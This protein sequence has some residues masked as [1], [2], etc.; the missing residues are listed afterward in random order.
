MTNPVKLVGVQYLRAIAALMVV[1][2]H[3]FSTAARYGGPETNTHWLAYGVD[4]F[5]VISGCIMWITT[6][7]RTIGA[8]EFYSK[9]I[10]RIVPLYW[11][12][13][14]A[15]AVAVF[16]VPSAFNTARFDL[17]HT[18]ASLLFIPSIHPS[19]GAFEPLL[20]Q[21]WTLN[22]EMFF[23]LLF[24]AALLISGLKRRL[25]VAAVVLA[26]FS[27]AGVFVDERT[28]LGFYTR[29]YLLEFG[30]GMLLGA[31]ILNGHRL[32]FGWAWVI[33]GFALL[34]ALNNSGLPFLVRASVPAI[35][36]VGGILSWEDRIGY[37]P[38]PKVMGDASYSIYLSNPLVIGVLTVISR[39][40]APIDSLAGTIVFV[41]VSFAICTMAGLVVYW[42]I[43]K[44]LLAWGKRQPRMKHGQDVP[45]PAR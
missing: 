38:L 40:V 16:L 28:V 18:M 29:S 6:S 17:W 32:R 26:L 11:T 5:F 31:L 1:A 43:E 45:A 44:P 3:G 42:I 19:S 14:I 15:M 36:I 2:H 37:H 34:P 21:G 12:L 9:R 20:I 13:T 25:A 24:G 39:R 8:L 23:Y 35:L 7:G 30:A 41:A 4:I 10:V 33:I 22:Y 27:F